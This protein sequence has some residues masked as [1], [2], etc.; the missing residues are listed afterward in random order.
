MNEWPTDL[1]LS[2]VPA[3]Y[4]SHSSLP[5]ER[6]SIIFHQDP[7][8]LPLDAEAR[9]AAAAAAQGIPFPGLAEWVVFKLDAVDANGVPLHPGP[10]FTRLVRGVET[11][12]E[13]IE[14]RDKACAW[15]GRSVELVEYSSLPRAYQAAFMAAVTQ[16]QPE[17]AMA[18]A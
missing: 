3:C 10:D 17:P 7:A 6:A 12:D 1:I 5:L 16:K 14:A 2:N 18:P 9:A 13:P 4:T 8:L 15:V 11:A